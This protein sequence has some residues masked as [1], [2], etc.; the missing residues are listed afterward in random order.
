MKSRLIL[1]IACLL[2]SCQTEALSPASC[3]AL[4][5]AARN[6]VGVTTQYDPA[7]VRLTYP[8]G[9]VPADRGVCTDVIVRAARAALTRD[10]Q[11]LVHQDMLMNFR[12][13]PKRWGLSKPDRNIDHRRVPNL[14]TFF[15]RCEKSVKPG[16]KPDD[17]MPGDLVTCTLPGNLPHIM[18]VSDRKNNDGLPLVIHN[19]G[20]GTREEDCLLM[21]PL[22]G[23]YRF[24]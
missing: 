4:V 2:V 13:Y 1:L 20:R 23:Q 10:L 15:S 5:E 7:Y 19:I 6:Q 11:K 22:T 9:D 12:L 16:R 17:F 24:K 21:F 3:T 18:L 14:Q 8:G